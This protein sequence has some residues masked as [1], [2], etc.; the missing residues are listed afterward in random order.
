MPP[1][2]TL[3]TEY[4]FYG[5]LFDFLHRTELF[6]LI[7]KNQ[8]DAE[9]GLPGNI[10][11][12][13]LVNKEGGKLNVNDYDAQ[14]TIQSKCSLEEVEQDDEMIADVEADLLVTATTAAESKNQLRT[15]SVST[16]NITNEHIPSTL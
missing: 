10:S 12:Q 9:Q 1:A 4:C 2:L 6:A 5:S 14:Q 3:I 16:P 8:S 15:T 13:Y 11:V 7:T